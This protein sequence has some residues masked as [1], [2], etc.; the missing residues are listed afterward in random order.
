METRPETDATPTG[1]PYHE[2]ETTITGT[3]ADDT[4]H[5]WSCRRRHIT[6]MRKHPAFTE[7][8]TGTIPGTT[9]EFA[10]FTI[11]DS[12]WNP[13]TGGRRRREMTDEQRKELSDRARRNF[14]K[15]TTK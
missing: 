3:D 4:I 13:A 15:E 14:Q 5:I 6:A 8:E 9:T 2:R 11:A 1:V 12:D 10:R 7:T